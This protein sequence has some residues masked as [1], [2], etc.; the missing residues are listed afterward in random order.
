[1]LAWVYGAENPYYAVT[2]KDGAFKIADV[3]PGSYTLV[4]WHEL[5]GEIE[6]PVTV[7]A[8]QAA[9]VKVELKKK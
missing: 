2:S 4:A 9:E 1:M 6:M 5:T 8:K 3:P 7:Q